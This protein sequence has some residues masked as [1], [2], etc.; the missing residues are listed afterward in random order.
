MMAKFRCVRHGSTAAVCTAML[1]ASVA[2]F[3]LGLNNDR[4]SVLQTCTHILC[5]KVWGEGGNLCATFNTYPKVRV[6]P[7]FHGRACFAM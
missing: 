7:R 2:D 5:F 6:K 3:H 1:D 4:S